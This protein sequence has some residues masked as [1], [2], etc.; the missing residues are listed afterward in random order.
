MSEL[1]SLVERLSRELDVSPKR[2]LEALQHLERRGLIRAR[3]TTNTQGAGH[4]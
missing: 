4:E 1:L 3:F 2:V